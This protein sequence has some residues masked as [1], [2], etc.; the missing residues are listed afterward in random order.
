M[1]LYAYRCERCDH[2]FE[3]HTRDGEPVCPECG[4]DWVETI[5]AVC[6]FELKGAGWAKD[7]YSKG[8]K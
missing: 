6:T 8:G 1:P 5:P 3:Q 7:G 2:E 4:G